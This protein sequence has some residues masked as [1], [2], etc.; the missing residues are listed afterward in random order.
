MR[1]DDKPLVGTFPTELSGFQRV[2][3]SKFQPLKVNVL[4]DIRSAQKLS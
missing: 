2:L 4:S 3:L 1:I